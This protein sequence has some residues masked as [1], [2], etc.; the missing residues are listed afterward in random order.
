MSCKNLLSGFPKIPRSPTPSSGKFAKSDSELKRKALIH[1]DQDLPI[2][3][4]ADVDSL[5]IDCQGLTVHYKLS[6]PESSP[7]RSLSASPFYEPSLT[8]SPSSI[9]PVRLK[10]ERPLMHQSK[11]QYRSFSYQFQNSPLYAPLLDDS[12]VSAT[13]VPSEISALNLEG[14]N[15][16]GCIFDPLNMDADGAEKGKFAVVL[17]HGFGGGVFSWRHVMGVLAHQVGCMVVAFDR[18]GWGLTSRPRKKEW[19]DRK[20]PNPYELES[21]VSYLAC[22][23]AT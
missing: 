1:E 17:V 6:L 9:Y 23:K 5:F 4:L 10:I 20:F 2:S 3:L 12:P 8:S 11:A 16:V 18:P 15:S 22:Y 7:S 14:S 13:F 19:E 21:Q